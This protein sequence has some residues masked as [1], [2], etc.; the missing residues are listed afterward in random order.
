VL[1]EPLKAFR[2][3]RRQ[4]PNRLAP[5]RSLGLPPLERCHRL[6]LRQLRERMCPPR[7]AQERLSE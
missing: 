7:E 5:K 6:T 3:S 2:S 4:A 1:P